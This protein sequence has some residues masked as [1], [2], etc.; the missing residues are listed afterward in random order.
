[1]DLAPL[2]A[3]VTRELRSGERDGTPTKVAVARR[4]Y[5]TD[6]ADL[7]DA[8]TD[9]E[10]LPRWFLPVSGDL[11]EGGTYQL[12]GNASGTVERCAAPE[13]FAVTWEY[14]GTVSW[15][16]VTLTEAEGGTTLELVHESPVEPE[17]WA[18]FGP[19]A[20]GLG[21]DLGLLGLGMYAESGEAVDPGFAASFNFTL[22]GQAFIRVAADGWRDAAIADGEDPAA[23]A[24]AAD[25]AYAAYTVA[26]EG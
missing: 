24:T 5:P 4:T 12:E 9:A 22:E 6:R 7:W 11:R 10:R 1:M 17:F 19:G 18:L 2:A 23:A 14:G 13:W 16:A 25:G 8:L 20:V 15:L 21:W 26:P 3:L